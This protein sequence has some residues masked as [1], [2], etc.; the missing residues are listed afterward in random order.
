M[1][2]SGKARLRTLFAT[3][4]ALAMTLSAAGGVLAGKPAHAGG[5]KDRDG[6]DASLWANGFP[7][8]EHFNLNIHGKKSNYQCD[9]T[10]AGGGSLFV[11]EYGTSEIEFIQN[12]KSSVENL[13]VLDKCGGFDGDAAEVQLPSGEYQVYA[14]ILAK[15]AKDNEPR[16]VVFYPK[17]VETCDD[18]GTENFSTATDCSESFLMGSGVVTEDGAFDMDSGSLERIDPTGGKGKGKSTAT[19]ISALFQWSGY[20]CAQEFD[21]D[22]DGAI[23][24]ADLNGTDLNNDTVVDEADLQIYLDTNCERYDSEWV[25]NI[26]DLVVY[27]WDYHNNGSKLLQI[28]FYPKDTTTFA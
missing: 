24:V 20:A 13:T 16:E 10:E 25:F 5:D 4:I 22:G 7:S 9:S 26:A 12:K 17:L 2:M 15:P 1:G 6:G 21:F 14:R 19:D 28:R 11:P 3:S 23:T 8:G 18:S 27:G